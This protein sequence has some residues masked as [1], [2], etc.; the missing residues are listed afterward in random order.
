MRRCFDLVRDTLAELKAA[1]RLRQRRSHVAAF[2]LLGMNLCLPRWFRQDGRLSQD[3]I[4]NEIASFALG[5]LITPPRRRSSAV[6]A[7]KP[8]R[9]RPQGGPSPAPPGASDVAETNSRIRRLALVIFTHGAVD[10]AL[11]KV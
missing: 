3:K 10:E 1:G 2:S 11:N 7:I 5:R 4:A 6:R 9:R 8:R